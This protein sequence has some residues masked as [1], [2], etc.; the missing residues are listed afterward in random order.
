MCVYCNTYTIVYSSTSVRPGPVSIAATRHDEVQYV[1]IGVPVG[2]SSPK[3]CPEH[4]A[5]Y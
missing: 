1:A 3:G 5:P 4:K 2:S